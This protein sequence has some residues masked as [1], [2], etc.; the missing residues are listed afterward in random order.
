MD[1]NLIKVTDETVISDA[2]ICYFDPV[3]ETIKRNWQRIYDGN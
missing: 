3:E 2:G 1:Y